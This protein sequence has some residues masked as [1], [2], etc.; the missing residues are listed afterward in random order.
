MPMGFSALSVKESHAHDMVL[1]VLK[2][3]CPSV[4]DYII[5]RK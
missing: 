5:E 3:F 1:H 4:N 2:Q